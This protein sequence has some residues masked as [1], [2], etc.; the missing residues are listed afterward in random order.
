[1]AFKL[2]YTGEEVQQI[3]DNTIENISQ[4]GT[5]LQKT[6]RTVSLP[7]EYGTTEYWASRVGYIP[8]EGTL[9]IYTDYETVEKDGQMVYVPG[10]KVGTGNAYVQDLA[11]TEDAL[12]TAKWDGK[13]NI[14][15]EHEV[16]NEV[17]IFNRD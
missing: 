14:D 6:N 12:D 16:E 5:P 4:N 8:A 13:L 9:I 3:L 1:M 17:L 7:I 15:D 2:T 10:V 11:F